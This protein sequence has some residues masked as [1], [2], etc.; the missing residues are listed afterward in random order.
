MKLGTRMLGAAVLV[1]LVGTMANA[2]IASSRHNFT[3]YG[4]SGGEICKPCH[5]PHFADTSVPR[6]WNHA[7]TT[8]TYTMH[9]GSGTAVDDFD[10]VSRMCMSCHDGTVALDSFGG[11]SGTTFVGPVANLGTDLTD[12]H[13]VGSDAEYPPTPLPSWWSGSF[14][15]TT[16]TG[17]TVGSGA[18]ALRL[19]AWDDAGT[20]KQV[21]GCTTC[22]NAHNRGGYSHMTA[23]SNAGSQLCLVCHIK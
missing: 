8:A 17:S 7:L 13:P 16:G 12:D 5:T 23:I 22:H 14:Q 20:T 19:K 4:W 21:V 6:L 2:Q 10:T 15:P 18:T 1:G 3:S 9:G 11:M